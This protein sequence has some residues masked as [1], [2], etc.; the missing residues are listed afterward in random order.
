VQSAAFLLPLAEVLG[1]LLE[2][3]DAAIAM[4]PPD[5]QASPDSVWTGPCGH[6][7]ALYL[8]SVSVSQSWLDTCVHCAA[9]L[10]AILL[11]S[12][13]VLSGSAILDIFAAK[14]IMSPELFVHAFT[15][16]EQAAQASQP[17]GDLGSLTKVGG[18]GA[19]FTSLN[20]Y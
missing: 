17:D 20:Q 2:W 9:T 16:L 13:F 19:S 5:P 8:A 6:Y 4:L 14:C 18:R 3:L 10:H 15:C 11:S 12:H 7:P 1:K